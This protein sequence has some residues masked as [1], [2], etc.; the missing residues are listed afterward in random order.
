MGKGFAVVNKRLADLTPDTKNANRGTERGGQMVEQSLRTYGAGRSILIDKHGRIIAGNKTAE[1]A[2]SIGLEDVLVVQTDGTKLVAVQRTDLD[3][4]TDKA[5]KELAIADNRAGQVSL[6]WDT[7]VLQELDVDLAKFWTEDELTALLK[8]PEIIPE[9][10]TDEDAV[11][12][13]PEEPETRLGDLYVLGK[14]RLLCGDSTNVYD[15][16]KLLGGDAPEM[17]FTDP[18]YGI[19]VQMGNPGTTCKGTILGDETTEVAADVFRLCAAYDVPM[20]FWGANHYAADAQ[21]PNASCWICWDKQES[22]NHIDQADCEFAWTNIKGPARIFHHLWAG[23]RRDSEKGEKRVHPTQKPIA[24]I[25]E[26]LA[27]F[28]AGKNILDLFGGSGSTLMACEKTGRKAYLMELD[29][30]YCDVIVKRWEEA[31]GKKAI[32]H[33]ASA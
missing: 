32:R 22:N 17:V 7:S 13:V 8:E 23:F 20:I 15:V 18:P 19:R 10:L 2:G 9:L 14:H 26:M 27:F 3:L 28:K 21:L 4:E 11:P 1:H 31:T 6:E 12:D 5:A 24:L 29:P 16:E 25:E 30:K 33:G